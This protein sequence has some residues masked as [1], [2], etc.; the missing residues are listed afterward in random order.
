MKKYLAV[1][2]RPIFFIVINFFLV[3]TLFSLLP[4]RLGD[5]VYNIGRISIIFYA[6]W[7]VARKN[8]GGVWQSAL[9]GTAIYFIDH[10]VLKGGIFLLNWLVRPQGLGLA[11]FSGVII[12]FVLFIPLAM[13]IAAL[14]GAY[15]SRRSES[16]QGRPY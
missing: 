3:N 11:A 9:A 14:G 1:I 5:V 15:A 4:D 12:S 2:R 13:I 7:L 6:G 10:V 16:A 8:L